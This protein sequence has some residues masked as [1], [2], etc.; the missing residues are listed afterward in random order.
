MAPFL[1]KTSPRTSKMAKNQAS[2]DQ[3]NHFT[4]NLLSF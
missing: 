3:Y 1:M 4:C 2:Y